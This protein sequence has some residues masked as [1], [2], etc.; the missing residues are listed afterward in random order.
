[1][2]EPM[3]PQSLSGP[4]VDPDHPWLGLPPFAEENH[5]YFF[6]RTAEVREVFLRVRENP[7]TVLYG[8]SGLG[9][10]SLLRAG[11]IP[12]LRVERFR[13]VRVLLDFT[14]RSATLVGQVRTAL[15][16]ACAGHGGNAAALLDG[17]S[18]LASLWEVCAHETIRPRDLAEQPPVLI[19]DQFEEV[20]TLTEQQVAA[21]GQRNA[22][23]VEL[24]AQ[25]GD[26]VENRAPVALQKTFLDD[27]R[28]ALTYDFS[29]STVRVVLSLRED[30]LA[31]LEQWR[32]TIPSLMRNRMPLR[33]LT[34]PQALEA[35]VRPGRMEGRNLVSD[36]VGEQI[37]RFV[38][39]RSEDA[40]LEEV[41]AVPP[42]VSLVCEQ[43]NE[44]RLKQSP[45]LT[46][47]SAELVASQGADI[48]Q[49]F[50]DESFADFPD[51]ER[52]AVREYLEDR[53]VTRAGG[54]RNPVAREDA[55]NEL[56]ERGVAAPT[57][58]LD[59]LIGRRLL[60]AE[61]R[62]GI[63]RLEITHDVLVPL[64]VRGRKERQERREIQ[65]AKRKQAEIEAQLVHEKRLRA[66][67]FAFV[68]VFVLLAL[69]GGSVWWFG[70]EQH[71]DIQGISAE[72]RHIT[73]EKIRAQLFESIERT[74]KDALAQADKAKSWE[75]RERLRQ[76]AEKAYTESVSRIDELADSFSQIEVSGRRSGARSPDP[77]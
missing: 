38:A 70:Y 36:Q 2:A 19:I 1:M 3:F 57:A 10:T 50:Y 42:L 6:G 18:P 5:R 37:V 55:V 56:T 65:R 53:M 11:L 7:L 52:E 35:V 75:E 14:E 23:V 62:G 4:T 68:F 72:A 20:F 45:E 73:K 29:P 51:S 22:E 27:P 33:L 21:A 43:L 44:A 31:H 60:T 39:K 24:F 61:W 58:V 13:P 67:A 9:K 49:R 32:S 12:K 47:V 8:Q 25:I 46:E 26:L 76:A 71:K 48:L 64:A 16:A 17:W 69:I 77:K 41:E 34:G 59:T 30:Y 40:P 74:R 28:R 15:A 66:F 54:H 63:Q